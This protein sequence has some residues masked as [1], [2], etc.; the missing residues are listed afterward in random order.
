MDLVLLRIYRR[1]KVASL[2]EAEQEPMNFSNLKEIL[3]FVTILNL[4]TKKTNYLKMIST[5]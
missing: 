5:L 3:F 4:Y 1:L 2:V